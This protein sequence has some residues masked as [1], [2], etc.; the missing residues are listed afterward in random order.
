MGLFF[1]VHAVKRCAPTRAF[2][3]RRSFVKRMLMKPF[4]GK[5]VKPKGPNGPKGP[6]ANQI[7]LLV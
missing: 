6:E 2:D 3:P 5:N 4:G 7:Q 1:G